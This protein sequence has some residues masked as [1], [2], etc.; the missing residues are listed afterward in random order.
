[1]EVTFGTLIGQGLTFLVFI[2]VT[3]K[4]VWPPLTQAMEDRRAKIAEG[5][6]AGEQAAKD[7]EVA[8]SEADDILKTAR[9][10]ANQIREQASTQASQI[11]EQA[12]ADALADRERQVEAARAEID[13]E[14]NRTRRELAGKVSD[15]AVAGA[16]KILSREIDRSA[17]EDL[18]K[19]L[20]AEL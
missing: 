19:Q 14:A 2:I 17:H 7:L 1:V 13:Q 11:K 15:L 9:E 3:W 8:R 20:A 6:A 5:L 12:R 4:Y 18:L 16:E 10:Q